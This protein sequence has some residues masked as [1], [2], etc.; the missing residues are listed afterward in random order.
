MDNIALIESF[1]DFKDE[2]GISKIDLMAIIE[3]SLKTLLRKRYDSDDH[4][5]V[6]VNLI[7]EIFRYF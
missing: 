6:I 1:G 3:D 7:R 2:K 4:F 5:D